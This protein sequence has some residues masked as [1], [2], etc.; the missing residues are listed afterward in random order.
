MTDADDGGAGATGV[1][2]RID[3]DAEGRYGWRVIAQ[4]G[5]AVAVS[6]RAF[7][8]YADCRA[9]FDDLRKEFTGQT[10][11]VQ[12]TATGNGWVWLLRRADGRPTAISA[13][14]YERRSTCQAAFERFLRLLREAGEVTGSCL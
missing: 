12:H 6:P 11:V 10:G 14:A 3:M 4:N 9:A 2:C 1:R 7:G 8:A 13:R 5:R